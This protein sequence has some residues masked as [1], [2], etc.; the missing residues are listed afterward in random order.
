MTNKRR[1]A[2]YILSSHWD[3]EWHM[4]FQDFRYRLVQLLDRV[5]DGLA[6]GR[7]AGPF[8]TD[9]Q[10][11]VLEDYLEVRPERRAEVEKLLRE[12]QIAA[13]PWYA[14]PDEFLVSG[15][16]L[17]RNLRL[18][19]ELVRGLGGEPSSA[20]ILCDQF[21]HNSQ[22]PQL[23][24]GFG[25]KGILLWRGV[26]L[27]HRRHFLWRGADGTELPAHRFGRRGYCDYA[28]E[29]R[30]IAE[31]DTR[32][33]AGRVAEDL[34]KY[35]AAEAA[36]TEIEPLLIFDGADHQEWDPAC[37]EVLRHRMERNDGAYE[38]VHGDLDRYL[39]EVAGQAEHIS[40]RY[41]GELREPGRYPLDQDQM[42]MIPGVASSR[43]WIHQ[44]NAECESL[45]C[46][47]AEPW[48]AV[49]QAATGGKHPDAY[50]ATAWKWLLQN[51]P[52]DSICGC[53][54]DQVHEDMK[55]RFSQCRRI[56]DRVTSEA[57]RQLATA[58][59][60]E[61]GDGELRLA[62]FNPLAEPLRQTAEITLQIPEAWPCFNEFF[63]YEPKPAFRIYDAQGNEVAYQRLAQ[64]MGRAKVRLLAERFPETYRTH[65]VTVSLALD[66]PACGY[67]TLSVRRGETD[68]PTRHPE[69][70]GMARS[71]RSMENEFL[72]ITIESG[73]TLT[74]TDKRSGQIYPRLLTVEDRADIGDGWF[75]GI[76]VNDQVW[77]SAACPAGVA[78]VHDGPMLTTFRIRT[79]MEVPAEFDHE[80][81]APS[82]RMLEMVIDSLVSLRPGSDRLEVVT[83]IV[84]PAADHRV[85]VL[86]PTGAEART[87]LCDTP[88]DVVERPIALVADN[89]LYREP[90]LETGP[91]Q[92]WTAVS[93][94]R[95]GLAVVSCGLPESGVRDLPERPLALTLFRS[96]R[97]TVFT[98][99]EPQGLLL[100]EKLTFRYEIVP[101]AGPIDPVRLCRLGQR[102]AAGLR[103]VQLTAKDLRAER[104][105]SGLPPRAGFLQVDGPVV[106]TSMRQVGDGLEVRL[107][108][109][110][111]DSAKTTL[112][113]TP[114]TVG[115]RG[116]AGVQRVDFESHTI[117]D[118][119]PVVDGVVKVTLRAKE[120]CTLRLVRT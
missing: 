75:H 118:S 11:I 116:P 87:Y 58:A 50:L 3:R 10:A 37:Y 20:G 27:I 2:Y 41:A 5:L 66:V 99:G 7:L 30:R 55:Y 47:W 70:P 110:G 8:T 120:I 53:S 105:G 104:S 64:A 88:F 23:L 77:T 46:Q 109:P 31:P 84:N 43:A 90:A 21:G 80:R 115:A 57:L 26:N 117:G 74:L 12:G 14:M 15:E 67:T 72:A 62:V 45:L 82:D 19:R 107:F 54:I 106:V 85:R 9:G 63:G 76:A 98:D 22:M 111:A 34:E 59:A 49:A 28:V 114:Q 13:G 78:L 92:S 39:A 95:R 91:Q 38:I 24:A 32:F 48:S 29:V 40:E 25:A 6:D 100:G 65:D 42:W 1:R 73:G 36:L 83:T 56:A 68:V 81:M 51:H 61:V 4:P 97:R 113:V 60:G 18:G 71:D 112:R 33:D 94:G 35:L 93:D 119:L 79:R 52:H 16:S 89:H 102:L 44:A 108:N 86:M 96:T 103:N 69:R 101:L 17:V